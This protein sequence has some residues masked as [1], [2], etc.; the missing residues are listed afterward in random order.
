M[1]MKQTVILLLLL[2]CGNISYAQSTDDDDFNALAPEDQELLAKIVELV[3]QGLSEAVMPDF[4]V[5]AKKYPKNY[6]VQYELAYN[7]YVLKRYDEIL[8]NREFLLGN[9]RASER[10]YQL[11]GNSYDLSGER[12]KA[13]KIYKEGLERFPQSGSLYM[14]LGVLY[15]LEKDYEKA[16]EYYN[17]GIEVDPNLSSNYYKA[18][19]IYLLSQSYKV[20]GLIYAES[21]ILLDPSDD[22]RHEE[23]AR[24]IIDCLKENIKMNVDDK[25]GF[26]VTLAK[27]SQM[28]IDEA[29]NTVYLSFP[30]IYEGAT[31][32]PL[33][34]LLLEHQ[35]FV[36]DMRQLIDIRKGLVDTYFSVTGNLYGNSMYLLEYQKR[37][38]DAGHWDAYNYFLFMQCFP[39]E[40]GEWYSANTSSMD[41]F[42][43]WYNNDPYTLGDGRSV[44][45]LQIF[46]SYRPIDLQEALG[47]QGRLIIEAKNADEGE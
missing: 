30:G 35:P 4:D 42:I 39:E 43:D 9:E 25:A 44:D 1:T 20:W 34:K 23:M 26:S 24:M 28:K 27:S 22:A 36:C 19:R 16:L 11:I 32:R 41:A 37:I 38:I 18:A 14:E 2:L 29:T 33:T 45:A 21:A 5:L 31:V 40:F 8:K 47:I 3:D 7:N 46:N 15:Y 10:S 12:K 17:R 6:L 13:A